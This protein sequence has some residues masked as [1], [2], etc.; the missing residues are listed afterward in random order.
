[1]TICK[2]IVKNNVVLLEE[3]A[4]LPDDA[5]V[6]VRLIESSPAPHEAFARVLANR[7]TRYV[8]MDKILEE[9]KQEREE[10]PDTWLKS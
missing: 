4:H 2:G 5:Q 10:H 7:I 1:M 8:G 6:E 3:G 9:D